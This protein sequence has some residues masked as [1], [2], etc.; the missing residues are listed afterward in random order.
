MFILLT[1]LHFADIIFEEPSQFIEH[2]SS[3]VK[4]FDVDDSDLGMCINSADQPPQ[5]SSDLPKPPLIGAH[6]VNVVAQ[7][8]IIKLAST[9]K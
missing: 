8:R 7:N 6:R 9:Q 1:S 4:L 2:N 3:Q 5:T